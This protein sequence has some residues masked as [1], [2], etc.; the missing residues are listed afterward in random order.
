MHH[1]SAV[2]R[3][4]GFR[5]GAAALTFVAL[6][7]GTALT[8]ASAATS[9]GSAALAGR[10]CTPTQG[11]PGCRLFNPTTAKQEFTV[12]SGVTSLDVRAVLRNLCLRVV[13]WVGVRA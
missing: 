4:A 2:S 3:R 9:A 13:R 5:C 10:A 12:P 1:G 11:F 7:A 8:G 6:A